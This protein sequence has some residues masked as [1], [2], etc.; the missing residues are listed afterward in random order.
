M[1]DL[2]SEAKAQR[3]TSVRFDQCICPAWSHFSDAGGTTKVC[4]DW[5]FVSGVSVVPPYLELIEEYRNG[6][7]KRHGRGL[8]GATPPALRQVGQAQQSRGLQGEAAGVQHRY[9]RDNMFCR[10][11]TVQSYCLSLW[12]S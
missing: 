12:R 9:N 2:A 10:P 1:L 8:V 6:D 7:W 4:A 3:Q 5:A 11:I